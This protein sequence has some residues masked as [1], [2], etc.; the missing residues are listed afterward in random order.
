M[1]AGHLHNFVLLLATQ[2]VSCHPA[3][4]RAA[5]L[6]WHS[7]ASIC[8]LALTNAFVLV[9]PVVAGQDVGFDPAN[10]TVTSLA[11][12][13]G[14]GASGSSTLM[15][16]KAYAVRCGQGGSCCVLCGQV[17]T[18]WLLLRAMRSGADRVASV[19]CMLRCWGT[20]PVGDCGGSSGWVIECCFASVRPRR[21]SWKLRFL[22]PLSGEFESLV[23]GLRH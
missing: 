18:W 5:A 16:N 13:T 12:T 23:G 14:S 19:V 9:P 7:G 6:H 11:D 10:M 21:E 1:L 17:R 3:N 8:Q 15:G 4:L 2:H 20:V 22:A